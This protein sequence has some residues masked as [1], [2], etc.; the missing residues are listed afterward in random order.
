MTRRSTEGSSRPRRFRPM[1]RG[2][3][4]SWQ[5][6]LRFLAVTMI[7]STPS[8]RDLLGDGSP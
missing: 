2:V 8:L 7:R 6:C 3:K 5:S 1:R 4:I